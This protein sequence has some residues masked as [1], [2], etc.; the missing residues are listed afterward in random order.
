VELGEELT[1]VPQR[2]KNFITSKVN[3]ELNLI[4]HPIHPKWH[5]VDGSKAEGTIWY[6]FILVSQGTS[7][8]EIAKL[9][10]V[11]N[12]KDPLVQ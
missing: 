5:N 9:K 10:Q 1:F 2:L 6:I 12:I 8:I 11:L 3:T 7:D 4:V